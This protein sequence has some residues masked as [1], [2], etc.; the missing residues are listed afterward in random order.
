MELEIGKKY[1][2]RFCI[3]NKYLV[4]K[5]QTWFSVKII[6]KIECNQIIKIE[7]RDLYPGF[8]WYKKILIV[9][10]QFILGATN[11]SDSAVSLWKKHL[12]ISYYVDGEIAKSC[13]DVSMNT[14]EFTILKQSIQEVLNKSDK[15]S[16]N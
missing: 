10:L 9:I 7:N 15:S 13:F 5:K 2:L 1:G 6:V 16:E 11:R 14:S 3:E 4:I 12:F 8:F